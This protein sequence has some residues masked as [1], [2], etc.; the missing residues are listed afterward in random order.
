MTSKPIYLD[1]HA[2]TPLDPR[3]LDAMMPFL[4]DEFGNASSDTHGYGHTAAEAVEAAREV[5]A[6][7]VGA[8]PAEVVFTSGATEA[9]NLAIKGTALALRSKGDHIVTCATEHPAVLDPVAGLEKQGFRTTVLPVA[10]DGTLDAETVAAAIDERTTV[11]SLMHANNEI[12]VIHDIEAIAGICAERGVIFHTDA[13]QTAGKFPIDM[14]TARIRLLSLSSHKFYGPKGVGALVVRR[15]KP[16]ARPVAQMEGGG[17]ERGYRSGTLNVP[18]IVGMAKAL[19]IAAAER[20]EEN[21]R[22]GK[23]R[24]QLRG[25]LFAEL[26]QLEENGAVENKLPHN[27]NVCFRYVDSA[28]LLNEVP[29]LAVSTGSACSSAD[30]EPSH[31]ILALGKDEEHAKSSIRFG[32]HRFTSEDDIARAV[33]L[34]IPAV[35]RLRAM[36]P[37]YEEMRKSRK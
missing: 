13:T 16:R 8:K 9:N 22:L 26:D 36:S 31:V 14:S 28:A 10:P 29:G 27:L 23:L 5:V 1:S 6:A 35:K 30:P 2:T 7:S 33:E 20:D 3:V 4:T 21:A 15:G 25:K 19:E 32:L 12:G 11:V 18:G 37:M 17:H 24:D 34:M